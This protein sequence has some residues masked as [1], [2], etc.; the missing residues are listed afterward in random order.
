M[1]RDVEDVEA[2]ALE[3]GLRMVHQLSMPKEAQPDAKL[4]RMSRT[5]GLS[6]RG[7]ALV[8]RPPLAPY[9]Q[10]HFAR[11]NEPDYTPLCIAENALMNTELA[12]RLQVA[13]PGAQALHYGATLGK[14]PTRASFARFVGERVFGRRVPPK[15]LA[16]LAGAGSVLEILSYVIADPGDVVLVPTPSYAGFWADLETRSELRIATVDTRSEDGFAFS[17][18]A[19]EA[20]YAKAQAEGLGSVRALLFTNPENPTGFVHSAD[21]L[22]EI[23]TW[24]DQRQVHVIFDELYALSVFK[25]GFV[26]AGSL[27]ESLGPRV[28]LVWAFSKDFGASGLR[29]ALLHSENPGVISAVDA[30]TYWSAASGDTLGRLSQAIDDVGWLDA[31]LLDARHRLAEA[32][33]KITDALDP[34][35]IRYLP[36]AGGIFVLCDLRDALRPQPGDAS[37]YAAEDRLWRSIL[38][39]TGANLTP[40]EACRIAEPGFFR[41]CYASQP[42]A[43]VVAA[44]EELG[45]WLRR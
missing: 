44:I 25:E 7:A 38:D 35:S 18:D 40:G 8:E 37:R 30:L 15:Q 23:L 42:T 2:V 29:C 12:A 1:A 21:I 10:E 13:S 34:A 33:Q 5:E 28:H 24:S 19:L 16:I 39:E 17:I 27:R 3:H 36:A 11:S 22:Q 31:Y 41:I 43:K 4:R 14:Q 45:A 26:S 32:H 6:R 20:A 9:I